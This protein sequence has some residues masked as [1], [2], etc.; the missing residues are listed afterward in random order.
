VHLADRLHRW[1]SVEK[2]RQHADWQL[3]YWLRLLVASEI[4]ELVELA[5]MLKRWRKEIVNDFVSYATNGVT[6][7]F[8]TKIKLLKRTGY[9]R[10]TFEHLK[11]RIFLE[12][13]GHP[14]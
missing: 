14:P 4:P 10:L 2:D 13:S 9:G 3:S 5:Q 8:N 12:C 6:E 1:Y 11:A 7:G